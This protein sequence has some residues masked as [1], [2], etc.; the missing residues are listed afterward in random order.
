MES[1]FSP[2]QMNVLKR[3]TWAAGEGLRIEFEFETIMT[4]P[5]SQAT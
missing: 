1:F 5:A 4:A 2:L 3:Q